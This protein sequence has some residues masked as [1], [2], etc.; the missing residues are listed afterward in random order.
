MYILVLHKV[1][2]SSLLSIPFLNLA[3]FNWLPRTNNSI[4]LINKYKNGD[5]QI[6]Q[7]FL[8]W[9]FTNGLQ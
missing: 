8:P 5:N 6:N 1:K 3:Y 2:P 9:I 4:L 7:V